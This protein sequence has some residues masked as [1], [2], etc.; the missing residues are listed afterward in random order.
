MDIMVIDDD[1]DFRDLLALVLGAEG[2]VVEA[3]KDA[4][5]ALERLRSGSQPSLIL[6]DM[7]MP[8]MDGEQFMRVLRDDPRLASIP[9]VIISGHQAAA[10]K[11][12][13]LGAVGHLVK[14]VE[15]AQL[16]SLLS[17]AAAKAAPA[18]APP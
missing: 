9:V 10:E 5:D 14:P 18:A 13:E 15:L 16:S 11:A 3:A 8:R 7:M 6:L 1:D 12:E 2:H 4:L 17:S